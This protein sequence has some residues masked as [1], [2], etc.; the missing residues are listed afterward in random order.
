L[1]RKLRAKYPNNGSKN[2]DQK[3]FGHKNK[4]KINA[5]KIPVPQKMPTIDLDESVL[6]FVSLQ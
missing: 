3:S 2:L 4:R 6:T 1:C 5:N